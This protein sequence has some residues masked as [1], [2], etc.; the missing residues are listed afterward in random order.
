MYI[1]KKNSIFA[2][3]KVSFNLAAITGNGTDRRGAFVR[4]ETSE[5]ND[6]L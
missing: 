1:L 2:L 4:T 3:S 5:T 6:F